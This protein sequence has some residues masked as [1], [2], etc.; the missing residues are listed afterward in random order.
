M[1]CAA[2]TYILQ[3]LLDL[4]DDLQ[5]LLLLGAGVWFRN[6]WW[7]RNATSSLARLR[8]MLGTYAATTYE[9]IKQWLL[10]KLL[11]ISVISAA[12]CLC[13]VRAACRVPR[14]MPRAENYCSVADSLSCRPR[15]RPTS[16]QHF[17][18]LALI[19]HPPCPMCQ[20]PCQYWPYVSFHCRWQWAAEGLISQTSV[21][22]PICAAHPRSWRSPWSHC[23]QEEGI[24]ISPRFSRRL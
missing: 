18:H 12:Y 23:V 15:W 14:A 17:R 11:Y 16:V 19:L 24:P 8:I 9:E 20:F 3:L 13:H 10:H 6:C 21:A 22:A 7:R 2:I 1:T 5:Q 4:V